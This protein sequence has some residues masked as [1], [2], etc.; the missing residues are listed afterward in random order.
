MREIIV[1]KENKKDL[2]DIPNYIKKGLMFR[3]VDSI[4]DVIKLSFPGKKSK[5]VKLLSRKVLQKG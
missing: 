5:K 2:D 4:E 1:P 3:L